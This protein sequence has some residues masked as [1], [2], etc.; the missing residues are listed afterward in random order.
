MKVICIKGVKKGTLN[1][2]GDSPL[3]SSLQIYET[4]VYTVVAQR[5]LDGYNFPEGQYYVL[6]ERGWDVGY[7]IF[8][9]LPLSDIDEAEI[10]LK[11][12]Q[13]QIL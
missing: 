5:T 7:G 6:A 12:E 8:N 3:P 10:L 4:D 2:N 13:K 9:F 1:T 11:R